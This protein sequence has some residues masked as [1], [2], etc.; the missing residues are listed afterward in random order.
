METKDFASVAELMEFTKRELANS[1]HI[2]FRGQNNDGYEITPSFSRFWERNGITGG[3]TERQRVYHLLL[4]SF[5]RRVV[6][7]GFVGENELE[8]FSDLEAYSQHFGCPTR[9]VDWSYSPYVAL[10]FAL[11]GTQVLSDFAPGRKGA[12]FLLNEMEH[13]RAVVHNRTNNTVD[14][15]ALSDLD[16]KNAAERSDQPPFS[17]NFESLQSYKVEQMTKLNSRLRIQMGC[18]YTAPLRYES[19]DQYSSSFDGTYPFLIKCTFPLENIGAHI[20]DLDLMG[21]NLGRIYDTVEGAAIDAQNSLLIDL[22][23]R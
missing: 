22:P 19:F 15:D 1:K 9:L 4:K 12:L 18:F 17:G 20:R 5:E 11:G 21:L 7:E 16:P 23:G 8:N 6:R 13:Y 10:F 3:S 14:A 2:V